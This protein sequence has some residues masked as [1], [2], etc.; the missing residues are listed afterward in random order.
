MKRVAALTIADAGAPSAPAR[1]RTRGDCA[2]GPRPCPWVGCRHHV[3]SLR[4]RTGGVITVD[5]SQL[6]LAPHATEDELDA[7]AD[8]IVQ[9]L[10]DL[11]MTCSLDS[12]HHELT[13][14]QLGKVFGVTP[15]R[16]RQ[17]LA[18]AMERLQRTAR[19]LAY[20]DMLETG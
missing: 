8:S 10:G 9:R 19:D 11:P 20:D 16:V 18:R 13:Y 14:Q 3:I 12:A 6:Q 4:R 17:L 2:N 15:Q 1:P 5:G 7:F